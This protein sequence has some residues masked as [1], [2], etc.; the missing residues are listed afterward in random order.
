MEIKTTSS[1]N[2]V[3][4]LCNST[5]EE[6][7]TQGI[8]MRI[9]CPNCGKYEI[10]ITV[11]RALQNNPD[12]KYIL[13]GLVFDNYYRQSKILRIEYD[14][15]NNTKDI[16]TIEK[17]YKLA[18]Y[19]YAE[20]TKRVSIKCI[21]S[22]CYAANIDEYNDLC[23]D[24]KQLRIITFDINNPMSDIF[25][26]YENIKMTLKGKT[27][28]EK[29]ID[30]YEKFEKVFMNTDKN[31]DTFNG[32]VIHMGDN[33]QLFKA[34]SHATVTATQNNGYN[35]AELQTLIDR[36]LQAIPQDASKE[37]TEQIKESTETIKAEMQSPAPKKN[38]IKTILAGL[39]GVVKTIEFASALAT[40]AQFF[41]G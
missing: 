35:I 40:L 25:P 26:R 39:G 4:P 15:L 37:T 8:C 14:H 24:L 33:S 17:L 27:A 20:T 36:L 7:P 13:S 3:C 6:L 22:C 41:S 11:Y 29:G 19:I 2:Y 18:E 1:D 5:A 16:Q 32:D 30:S 31:G 9:Y 28:F 10:I 38:M 23:N 12:I 21:F 34:S